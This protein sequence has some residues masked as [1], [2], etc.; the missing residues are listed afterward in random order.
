MTIYM[1]TLLYVVSQPSL[2]PQPLRLDLIV[3]LNSIS[4][5][6]GAAQALNSSQ[7]LRR[8]TMRRRIFF[9]G[10]PF[11]KIKGNLF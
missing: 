8:Q 11:D 4:F 3:R 9:L 10:N 1:C 6:C 2:A 7:L 5:R